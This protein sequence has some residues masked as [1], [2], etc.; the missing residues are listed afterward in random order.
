M[1][2]GKPA[3]W[4]TPLVASCLDMPEKDLDPRAALTQYGLDSLGIAELTAAIEDRAGLS[5]PEWLLLDCPT[6]ESIDQFL[7]RD[8]SVSNSRLERRLAPPPVRQMLVDSRLPVDC[9]PACQY[10]ISEPQFV[11][12]TGATGFL[13]SHILDCLLRETIAKVI[14]MARPSAGSSPQQRLE[15]ALQKYGLVKDAYADR[16]EVIAGDLCRP[17]LGLPAHQFARLADEV[18][19][20]YHSAATVNWAHSYRQLKPANVDGTRELI[21]FACWR[22]PKAFHFVSSLAVCYSTL[23]PREVSENQ[24]IRGLGGGLYL[25]YA[26]SK[27]VAECLIREAVDRGLRAS[28]FRPSL[29]CGNSISGISNHHDLLSTL[30]KGWRPEEPGWELIASQERS[31]AIP[32]KQAV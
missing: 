12:L 15:R 4:L 5:V 22:H 6:L 9:Q 28:V 23:A 2:Q 26:Q 7:C 29:V 19:T 25:G 3:A 27:Y 32:V 30:I 21:R 8:A 18:D 1:E 20:I 13:G 11:L 17:S 14:C 31:E 16:V 24:E 10:P